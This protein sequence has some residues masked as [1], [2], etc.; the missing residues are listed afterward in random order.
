MSTQSFFR[1]RPV[2]VVLILLSI[3]YAVSI[4]LNLWLGNVDSQR[5]NQQLSHV[6]YWA[7]FWN[8]VVAILCFVSQ[9]MMRRQTRTFFLAGGCALSVAFLIVIR[10]WVAGLRQGRNPFPVME[11]VL[12]WPPFLYAIFYALRESKHEAA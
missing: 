5:G 9:R 8:A 10:T 2:S 4:P 6:L 1:W 3:V 7:A 11:A 12:I